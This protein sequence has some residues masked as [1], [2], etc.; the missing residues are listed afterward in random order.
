M[1]NKYIK[2]IELYILYM[3][4]VMFGTFFGIYLAQTYKIPNIKDK[5]KELEKYLRE[6]KVIEDKTPDDEK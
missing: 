3:W 2:F 4:R 6:N 1:L 5:L